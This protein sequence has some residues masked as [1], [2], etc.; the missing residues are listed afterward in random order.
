MHDPHVA[1][2]L[3]LNFSGTAG[4]ARELSHGGY[5]GRDDPS[6]RVRVETQEPASIKQ[7]HAKL[8]RRDSAGT[9]SWGSACACVRARAW[10]WGGVRP[11]GGIPGGPITPHVTQDSG[12]RGQHRRSRQAPTYSSE[13]ST[14]MESGR[15]PDSLL[16]TTESDLS[17]MRYSD[18][19]W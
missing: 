5:C 15:V 7:Q 17:R 3:R 1:A 12:R 6:D 8:H 16:D 19:R 4:D 10:G 18:C 9:T 13:L 2:A 11:R 14:E